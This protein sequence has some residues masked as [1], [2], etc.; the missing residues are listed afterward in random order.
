MTKIEALER[1]VQSLSAEELASFRA[2]FAAYDSA[3]WDRQLEDD[4]HA[5]KL[6][7]LADAAL[8]DHRAG[9][10]RKL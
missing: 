10:S 1:E 7:G 8:T 4:V 6:D 2:W 5:G 3:A 9:R